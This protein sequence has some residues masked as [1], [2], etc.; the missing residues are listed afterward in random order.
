VAV[1]D[2]SMPI[3]YVILIP[4]IL[5]WVYTCECL[6]LLEKSAGEPDLLV[7]TN[8]QMPLIFQ[9]SIVQLVG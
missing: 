4:P 3:K 7:N 8:K 9:G 5:E 1:V 2:E 6:C